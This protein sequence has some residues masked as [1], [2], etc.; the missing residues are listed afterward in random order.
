MAIVD[1]KP[2]RLHPAE[3]LFRQ[4]IETVQWL[5]IALI[6]AL[7]FRAFIMQPYRI[8]TGSMARSLKGA[9]FGLFCQRCGFGFDRGFDSGEY[10]LPK[11]VLPESG[12]EIPVDCRCPNCG[13]VMN[14]DEP[15]WVANGDRILVLKCCYQFT[16]PKRWDVVV[17]KE[18][19]DPVENVIKRLIALPSETVEIID[20]DI[21][22]N[23]RIAVKPDK[24]QEKLWIP[25]FDNDYQPFRPA[26]QSIDNQ[27]PW[28]F[29][30]SDWR[31]DADNVTCFETVQAGDEFCELV[32]DGS[33]GNALRAGYAYNG[34]AYLDERPYCSDLKVRFFARAHGGLRAGA[35]LSKYGQSW[36]GWVEGDKMLLA[37]IIENKVEKLVEKPLRRQID[38]NSVIVFANVDHRLTFSC[39]DDTISYDLGGGPDDMGDR[40]TDKAPLVGILAAGRVSISHLAIFRDIHYT[41]QHFYGNEGSARA[42]EG[43]AFTLENDEYFVLGDNSPNS[44]DGRWWA[45]PGT[46][47]NGIRYRA[48]I[49]PRDYLV[50]KAVFVYWPSGFRLFQK[51][52]PAIIPN[53]GQIRF[54]YGGSGR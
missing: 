7:F 51:S 5:L 32:Y 1:G 21:Y 6:L 16:E 48:G 45:R 11:D 2:H 37:K 50:G 52:R 41:V 28:Q 15:I 17:F 24:L 19:S 43:N 3:S 26:V 10:G 31:I 40:L 54:I 13:Y 23:G 30:S 33:A 47:N 53:V 22:I 9:H 34:D 39:N 20:G 46:G 27:S 49:V 25:V 35:Q 8:P 38:D 18:P 14:F 36:S 12:K 44:H 29:D 42:G 4:T